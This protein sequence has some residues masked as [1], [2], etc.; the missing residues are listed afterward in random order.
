[1]HPPHAHSVEIDVVLSAR[2]SLG[3]FQKTNTKM[4]GMFVTK[5]KENAMFFS[6][7]VTFCQI[8]PLLE[9]VWIS[10]VKK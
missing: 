1:M 3:S 10:A 4:S 7:I 2:S 5:K 6:R 8:S 9:M